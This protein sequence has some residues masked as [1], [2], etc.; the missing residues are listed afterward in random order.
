MVADTPAYQDVMQRAKYVVSNMNL[1]ASVVKRAG[2]VHVQTQAGA[3]RYRILADADALVHRFVAGVGALFVLGAP[4]RDDCILAASLL[5]NCSVSAV[6]SGCSAL[7]SLLALSFL[8]ME[9]V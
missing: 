8:V 1:P 3:A 7:W 6:I 9:Q 5:D 4:P 2:Q